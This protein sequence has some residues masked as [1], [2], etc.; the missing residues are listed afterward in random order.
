MR[1]AVTTGHTAGVRVLVV[2]DDP[3]LR[4]VLG[5]G[6]REAGYVVDLVDD[7]DGAID[8]L[9]AYE[10]GVCIL[11]W[12]LPGRSGLEV[13]SWAR[14]KGIAAPVL[15][16]TARDAPADR[17]AALDAG[18][19]DYLVK[20]F[21][22]GE[23]LARL[24]ALLRRPAGERGPLLRCGSLALD[25]ASR[26]AVVGGEEVSFT[27]RELAILELL[28]RRSPAIVSRRSIAVQAWDDEWDAV[29]SNTIDVHIARLRAKLARA[30]VRVETVRGAG[31]RLVAVPSSG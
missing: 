22:Y 6:L 19:D 21:D 15:M 12:R 9:R 25:P 18:A 27:P 8:H 20:P 13:L 7:G 31:Y 26:R 24:R 4:S 17:V 23:L 3:G 5:R 10:Y 14:R 30:D 28:V 2:E 1:R 16:L 29:G 11:D